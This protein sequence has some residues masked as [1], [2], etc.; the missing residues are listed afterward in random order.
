MLMQARAWC[1]MLPIGMEESVAV[2]SRTADGL[3]VARLR[4]CH[5]HPTRPGLIVRLAGSQYCRW[6]LGTMRAEHIAV[7]IGQSRGCRSASSCRFRATGV[8]RIRRPRGP[9]PHTSQLDVPVYHAIVGQVV[10][11]MFSGS[12]EHCRSQSSVNLGASSTSTT[13]IAIPLCSIISSDAGVSG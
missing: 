7:S 2:T 9:R 13:L 1:P 12:I 10:V 3:R 11:A 6:S 4:G 5:V 8:E